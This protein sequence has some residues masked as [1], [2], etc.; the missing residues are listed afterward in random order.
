MKSILSS[1]LLALLTFTLCALADQLVLA[2]TPP[3]CLLQA[4]NTR[5]QPFNL[6]A[7][8]GNE[9]TGIQEAI[10]SLCEG[11]QSAAQSAFIATCS[12]AGSS[13]VP[14]TST[15]SQTTTPSSSIAYV[16][17][18]TING[19]TII[20]STTDATATKGGSASSKSSAG[21]ALATGNAAAE[22]KQVGS[23]AAAVIAIAGVVAIL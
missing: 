5:S 10:A 4:L 1:L 23:F 22:V 15:S 14:Y 9:A 16:Y 21:G 3:A 13:V 20:A 2:D 6:S 11:M 12:S 19:S 7:I 17:T 18:T 8:C